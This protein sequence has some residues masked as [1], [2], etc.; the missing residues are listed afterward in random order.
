[1]L[2]MLDVL[3]TNPDAKPIHDVDD[4]GTLTADTST[5]GTQWGTGGMITKLTAARIA[6]AAGCTM[7]ICSSSDPEAIERI[8]AGEQV[9]TKFHPL[10]H[11]LR[12]RKRWLL[13]G[14]GGDKDLYSYM[15]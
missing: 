7:V 1:M 8:L 12:G 10:E 14:A 5:T 15:S 11:S 9:G 13:S 3:Q 4:I 6:T 2:N